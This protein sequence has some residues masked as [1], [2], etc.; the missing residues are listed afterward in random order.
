MDVSCISR[1]CAYC[2]S[3]AWKACNRNVMSWGHLSHDRSGMLV[4]PSKVSV[5]GGVALIVRFALS[6]SIF[7]ENL[8]MTLKN[9][10]LQ[11]AS[12][13][14]QAVL[15]ISLR[16]DRLWLLALARMT[17]S[18]LAFLCILHLHLANGRDILSISFEQMSGPWTYGLSLQR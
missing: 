10:R 11:C 12:L 3:I 8:S 14:T 13:E 6:K 9:M 17:S 18:A 5:R 7:P 2:T 1:M 16:C 15:R 4:S